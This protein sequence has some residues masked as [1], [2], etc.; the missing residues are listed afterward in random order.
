MLLYKPNAVLGIRSRSHFFYQ[1]SCVLHQTIVMQIRTHDYTV[2]KLFCFIHFLKLLFCAGAN[3]V[4]IVLSTQRDGSPQDLH[5][6]I[7]WLCTSHGLCFVCKTERAC[8]LWLVHFYIYLA[9]IHG[10]VIWTLYE[11]YVT[12]V[13]FFQYM[14]CFKI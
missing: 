2:H 14:V 13:A 12:V 8:E 4:L 1:C 10:L 6:Y 5:K 3:N 7:E 9:Q 11:N